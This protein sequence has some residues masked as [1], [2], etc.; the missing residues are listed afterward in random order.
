MARGG[1]TQKSDVIKWQASFEAAREAEHARLRNEEVDR[2]H[3]VTPALGL[4]EISRCAT[5]DKRLRWQAEAEAAC[6][7]WGKIRAVLEP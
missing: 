5:D 1:A 3:A 2:A 4:I 6:Q 7:T